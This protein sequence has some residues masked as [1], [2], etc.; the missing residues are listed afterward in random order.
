[1]IVR[2]RIELAAELRAWLARSQTGRV[3]VAVAEQPAP[4]IGYFCPTYDSG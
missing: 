3:Q 2:D 1:M 4:P